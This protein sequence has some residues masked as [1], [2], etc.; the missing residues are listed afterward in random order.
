MAAARLRSSTAVT[1]ATHSASHTV[2]TPSADP[3]SAAPSEIASTWTGKR[4]RA[5]SA[6]PPST[7]GRYPHALGATW[8]CWFQPCEVKAHSSDAVTATAIPAS[9]ARRRV[10]EEYRIPTEGTSSRRPGHRPEDDGG[11]PGDDAR[12]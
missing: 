12:A 10:R 2:H 4:R 1:N 9:T 8:P 7:T 3:H 11:S 5:S 6:A